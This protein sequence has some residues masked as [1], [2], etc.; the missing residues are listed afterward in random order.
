MHNAQAAPARAFDAADLTPGEF[1]RLAAIARADAGLALADTKKQMV[2]SRLSR[3]IKR[4]GY[5]SFDDYIRAVEQD[6][7]GAEREGLINLLTTNV[8]S[9][10]REGHHFKTLASEILPDLVARAR[11]GEVVRIWSA[12]CSTGQEPYSI[13][14]QA[15]S[16]AGDL[17]NHD[18]RILAT[19]IDRIVLQAGRAATYAMRELEGIPE[20]FRAKFTRQAPDDPAHFTVTDD[21]RQLVAFR[22]LNLMADWP[23]KHRFDAIFCRNVV[24]YFDDEVQASLWPRFSKALTDR[25][26]FFL[27]HS[28]RMD[29][30]MAAQ[31]ANVGVT[32]FR[33][34][35][36]T[37]G[38]D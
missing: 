16:M 2:Q 21:V 12:G 38:A 7:D 5:Q 9:F 11:K 35:L 8:S 31:F 25:G 32:T 26:W 37:M 3:H 14:M 15:L 1:A 10:F 30:S 29:A 27:G 19:D 6:K 13:A 18:F 22:H 23:M 34:N 28:E 33:K 24:I 36:R 20:A 4:T 17:G